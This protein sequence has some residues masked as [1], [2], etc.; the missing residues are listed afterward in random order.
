MISGGSI[1]EVGFVEV[2]ITEVCH[3]HAE[4]RLV[5]FPV[6]RLEPTEPVLKQKFNENYIFKNYDIFDFLLF[7]FYTHFL[8]LVSGTGFFSRRSDQEP[9]PSDLLLE[10][11]IN[12]NFLSSIIQSIK[13]FHC[14]QTQKKKS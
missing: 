9:E 10:Q 6:Q 14:K 11:S 4:P 3:G 1:A 8:F 7:T 13:F 12:L 2:D 5:V